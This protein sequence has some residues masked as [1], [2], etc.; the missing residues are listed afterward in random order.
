MSNSVKSFSLQKEDSLFDKVVTLIEDARK[1]ISTTVNT[2]EVYTK[3]HIGKFIVESEQSGK[4]RAAYGRSV[5]KE[6]SRKLTNRFG[7]GWS[8]ENLTLFRKFYLIY[9]NTLM[10]HKKIVSGVYE[11]QK[12]ISEIGEPVFNLSWSHYLILMRIKDVNTRSFYEIESFQQNWSVRQLRRQYCSSL[13]ERLAL[14]RNKGEVMRLAS[15]GQTVE[16][17]LDIIKNPLTLEFIGLKPDESYTES[18][19][20][21]AIISRMQEFLLEMGK[22][23][24]F[25][26]RQKRFTFDEEFFY[27][28]LVLYNRLL[29]CYCLIDF[30][31][32]K[33]THQDL[34]QMQ[35]YVNY[36]DIFV[37]KDFEKPTIGILVCREKNDTLV[38]LTL[39]HNSNIYATDYCLY[40][41]DKNLLES[42]LKEWIEEYEDPKNI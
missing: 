33:L 35:M 34:G 39:P 6:L 8:V 25:E 26:A 7:L 37:K 12:G 30:K 15:E 9:S 22:G 20:E 4:R 17:P 2:A 24:L 1:K 11:I 31:I 5:L 36:F 16:C 21:E 38:K 29:Q 27:V 42:K 10:D 41:P 14:S 19:L 40:I 32:D 28:D 3:Y 23:F 13:Y 18:K